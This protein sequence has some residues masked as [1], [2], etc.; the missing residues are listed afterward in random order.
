LSDPRTAP[1]DLPKRSPKIVFVAGA[2]LL[3]LPLIIVLAQNSTCV[4][5]T[6]GCFGSDANRIIDAVFPYPM[7]C[8]GLLIGYGMK[9][10][11]DS[12]EEKE[13]LTAE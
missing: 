3:L 13:D 12:K 5:G 11:A 4:S 8:G 7:L 10:L 2:I 6:F 9:I 1:R